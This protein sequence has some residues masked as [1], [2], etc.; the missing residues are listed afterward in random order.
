MEFKIQIFQAWKVMELG[1]G[2]GKS[3]KVVKNEPSDCRIS[4]PCTFSDFTYIVIIHYQTWFDL[5]FSWFSTCIWK[6]DLFDIRLIKQFWKD[7]ENGHKWS[8]K[9]LENAH[10]KFLE[11]HGKPLS[12]FCTH[13]VYL[14]SCHLCMF[15]W[16]L[17][18]QHITACLNLKG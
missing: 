1:L 14:L 3:L 11:S 16:N 12:V 9:V 4:D 18:D 7:M 15:R 17:I 10:K 6:S 5:L 2:P 8:W 13:H